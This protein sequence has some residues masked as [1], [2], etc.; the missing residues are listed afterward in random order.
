MTQ[1][2][3]AAT[4]QQAT[5]PRGNPSP[6]VDMWK[7][8]GYKSEVATAIGMEIGYSSLAQVNELKDID[9]AT[10]FVKNIR[11]WK[12]GTDGYKVSLRAERNT[13]KLLFSS[14]STSSI[15]YNQYLENRLLDLV[16][17]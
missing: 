14:T 12:D 15:Q 4:S 5:S 9:D 16:I 7:R 17:K 11:R 1:G 8:L 13:Q 6:M 10:N 2:T 3:A